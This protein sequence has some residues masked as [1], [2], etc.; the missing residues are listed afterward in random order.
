MRPGL[1]LAG[2]CAVEPLSRD[3]QVLLLE[4]GGLCA[5]AL[6]KGGGFRL[7]G[8]IPGQIADAIKIQ[9]LNPLVRLRFIDRAVSACAADADR[10]VDAMLSGYVRA[11]IGSMEEQVVKIS[12]E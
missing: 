10:E 5:A 7:V 1:P 9:R 6:E 4:T 3:A 2:Q 8:Q 12:G 11:I